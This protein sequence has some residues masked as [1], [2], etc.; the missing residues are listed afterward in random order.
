MRLS[1]ILPVYSEEEILISLV[2]QL[3]KLVR[4]HLYEIILLVSPRSSERSVAICKNLAETRRDV[5]FFFQK[6]NPGLG[7]AVREGLQHAT[8]THVLLMDSDG[9]MSPVAVPRMIAKMEQSG[10]DMVVGSRWMKG[11]GVEGYDPIKL[12]FNRAFQILFKIM[13]LTNLHDLTLGFK[14]MN[15]RIIDTLVF[16]SD[17][18]DIAIETT[19]KP[20]KYGYRVE[21]IPVVWRGRKSGVS[22]NNMSINVRYLL[23]G[24]WVRIH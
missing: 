9:E 15:R 16:R 23:R 20:I 8:G 1:I 22:K 3:E 13:F 19:I 2:D 7:K 4:D 14:L 24:L 6:R 17:F 10:C 18:H 12:V 11:G 21:E 5:K